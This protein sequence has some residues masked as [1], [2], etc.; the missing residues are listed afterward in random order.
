MKPANR[1]VATL[2]SLS[3]ATLAHAQTSAASAQPSTPPTLIGSI[4]TRT[5]WPQAKPDDVKSPE[6]ILNAVY[7]VISGPKGQARDWDRM[8]S[9]FIPDARLIPA[10]TSAASGRSD[11]V[12]LTIDGYISRSQGRMTTNGFFERSIH[13]EIE[14]FG[15]IVQVWSTYESR[16]SADDPAPFTR[17]I[18]SFQLLKDGD[19]YWVVNIFWDSESP[20]NPIPAKYLPK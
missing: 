16:H 19:R 14:Q 6:A 5:D 20:A 4:A 13:N 9:L 8:R 2:L 12:V 7:S 10:T 1:I 18:N 17:G 15:N 3:L 11:A